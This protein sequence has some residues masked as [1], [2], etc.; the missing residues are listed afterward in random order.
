MN[1]LSP[2]CTRALEKQRLTLA[3]IAE[4]GQIAT[5]KAAS[6]EADRRGPPPLIEAEWP[7]HGKCGCNALPYRAECRPQFRP[8]VPTRRAG[9]S[10]PTFAS[11][12][13]ASGI[14]R[15][16]RRLFTSLARQTSPWAV[17][18]SAART[19]SRLL[20]RC[21]PTPAGAATPAPRRPD[22]R[23]AGSR[24]T[25]RAPPRCA[26]ASLILRGDQ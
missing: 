24:P 5:L 11:A 10:D 17:R 23:P 25:D 12:T 3:D 2:I 15:T 26:A 9:Y 8:I 13:P 4:V 19:A 14:H 6:D 18:I 21:R 7:L 1:A 22:T 20:M 16:I